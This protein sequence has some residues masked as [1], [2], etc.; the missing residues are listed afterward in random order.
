MK[1]LIGVT[2]WAFMMCAG[3]IVGAAVQPDGTAANTV[4]AQ[5]AIVEQDEDE[6]EETSAEET[7]AEEVLTY[8]YVAQPGDSYTKMARKAVQTFGITDEVN[9]TGAQIVY[10]ETQLT[11]LAGSPLLDI[12]QDV[13]L[14]KADVSEW[15]DKALELTEEE[16]AAWNT[17]VPSVDFNTDAVGEPQE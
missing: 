5:E 15:V 11:Q 4:Y 17:Y 9:L 8:N 3:Y 14:V 16:E 7:E 13:E 6:S 12:D 2:A 1:M 10:A